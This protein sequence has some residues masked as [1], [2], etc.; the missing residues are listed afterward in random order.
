MR[1]IIALFLAGGLTLSVMPG[2]GA[3]T[4]EPQLAIVCHDDGCE[5][6]ALD[7]DRLH[8]VALFTADGTTIEASLVPVGD[9]EGE[10]DRVEL[11][12]SEG[13][14]TLTVETDDD[15][16]VEI[17]ATEPGDYQGE[18]VLSSESS[19]SSLAFGARFGKALLSEESWQAWD[20]WADQSPEA[21]RADILEWNSEMKKLDAAA[22]K[23]NKQAKQA[24]NDKRRETNREAA[25]K[26]GEKTL[27]AQAAASAAVPSSAAAVAPPA[28]SAPQSASA[29]VGTSHAP[30][31]GG[32]SVAGGAASGG[33][34]PVSGGTQETETG[35]ETEELVEEPQVEAGQGQSSISALQAAPETEPHQAVAAQQD[36]FVEGAVLGA[37]IIALLVGLL[38]F[39]M[40]LG[41]ARGLRRATEQ[42]D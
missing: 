37:G 21:I 39:A 5:V 10:P 7:D 22:E 29:P 9:V 27:Q 28:A 17:S 13:P 3:E 42:K 31:T 2:A 14:G 35:E 36:R 11:T 33:T 23:L 25:R 20:A 24:D 1:K 4:P 41:E 18:L 32:S 30:A 19:S 26:H 15:G 38:K 12:E 16:S 8:D 6:F 40:A 34:A